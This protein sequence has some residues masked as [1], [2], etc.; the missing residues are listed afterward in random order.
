MK[1]PNI[2]ALLRS[3]SRHPEFGQFTIGLG[4]GGPDHRNNN[5]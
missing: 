1:D 4:I 3:F 2:L 5:G